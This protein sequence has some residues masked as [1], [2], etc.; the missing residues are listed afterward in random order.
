MTIKQ[1]ENKTTAPETIAIGNAS[2][3]EKRLRT[4]QETVKHIMVVQRMLANVQVEMMRRSLTH[5]QSK[6][7]SPEF[8]MFVEHTDKLK[9]S[10]YGSPEY[11]ENLEKMKTQGLAHHYKHNL[12]H[13]EHYDEGIEGMDLISVI[14]MFFDWMAA[15]QRHDT[16]DIYDSIRIN[17]TRFGLT[18]QL[19]KIFENT[20]RSYS[21]TFGGLH[22]QSD[23]EKEQSSRQLIR[24]KLA[25]RFPDVAASQNS[26]S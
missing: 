7:I 11:L 16:G 4:Y 22:L 15:C 6:L 14:E 26:D 5:D 17:Q 1:V 12:H 13:P 3:E 9:G 2:T 21:N 25:N 20:A 8:D 10:V 18:D 24:T 23:I 19:C